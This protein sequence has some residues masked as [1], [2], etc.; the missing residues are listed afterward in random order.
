MFY[1]P[2]LCPGGVGNAGGEMS[3]KSCEQRNSAAIRLLD[4]LIPL[5]GRQIS[6]VRRRS[7]ICV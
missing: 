2:V 3:G 7:G 4:R 1:A 6:A 5:I